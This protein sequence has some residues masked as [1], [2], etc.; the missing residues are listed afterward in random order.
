MR[1]KLLA[2]FILTFIIIFVIRAYGD[3]TTG[4]FPTYGYV[5]FIWWTFLYSLIPIIPAF[6]IFQ[7]ASPPTRQSGMPTSNYANNLLQSIGKVIISLIAIVIGTYAGFWV[8]LAVK[9]PPP[10]AELDFGGGPFGALIGAVVG[11]LLCW[12][13]FVKRKRA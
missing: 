7:I 2:V 9:Q 13:I 10:G 1:K 4:G 3:Y 8:G 6:F 5:H 11:L 12:Y